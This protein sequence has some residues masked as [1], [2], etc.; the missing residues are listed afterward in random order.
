[1]PLS[2]LARALRSRMYYNFD[3]RGVHFIPERKVQVRNR[4]KVLLDLGR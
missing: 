1:M 3:H 4:G 2:L